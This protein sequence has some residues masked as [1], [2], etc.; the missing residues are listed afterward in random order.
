MFAANRLVRRLPWGQKDQINQVVIFCLIFGQI[1]KSLSNRSSFAVGISF[2][3]KVI[4][5]FGGL[6]WRAMQ[7]H[8]S[9]TIN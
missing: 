4:H 5:H 2:F 8:S 9:L 7:L 3:N 1:S 6:S